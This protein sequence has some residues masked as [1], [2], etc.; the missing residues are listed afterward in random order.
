[1]EMEFEM[2]ALKVNDTW[3]LVPHPTS[4]NVFGSKWVFR[5]KFCSNGS[6]ECLKAC[7]VAHGFTQIPGQDYSLTFSPIIK[8]VTVRIVLSH[9]VLNQWLLHRLDVKNAFLNGN[10]TNTVFIEQSLVLLI[11]DFHI[12]YVV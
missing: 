12:M 1:M 11:K 6:I 5:T 7:L 4:S 10:L 3:E 2:D 9:A 8:L